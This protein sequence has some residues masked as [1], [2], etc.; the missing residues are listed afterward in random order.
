MFRRHSFCLI[1]ESSSLKGAYGYCYLSNQL[2]LNIT[3]VIYNVF[4][5]GVFLRLNKIL[6]E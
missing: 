5:D 1:G 4:T 2:K 3:K 6:H